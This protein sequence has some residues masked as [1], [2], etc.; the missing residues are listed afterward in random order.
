MAAAFKKGRK[1]ELVRECI[2]RRRRRR[3]LYQVFLVLALTAGGL[4]LTIRYVE[5]TMLPAWMETPAR[6][7]AFDPSAAWEEVREL[8]DEARANEF[9]GRRELAEKN[10]IRALA[11]IRELKRRAPAFNREEVLRAEQLS[12]D[13]VRALK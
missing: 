5:D 9:R 10:Y 6:E 3:I 12:R 8:I 7:R 1:A 13:K 11:L 2:R 4:Y